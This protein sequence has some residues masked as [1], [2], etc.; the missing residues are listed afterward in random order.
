ML[1]NGLEGYY[2]IINVGGNAARKYTILFQRPL[3]K[4]G[5]TVDNAESE[6]YV[7]F[8]ALYFDIKG[9]IEIPEVITSDSVA[10][11][12]KNYTFDDLSVN[13]YGS[14]YR[15]YKTLDEAKENAY[16]CYYY[17]CY[18]FYRKL[19]MDISFKKYYSY[20]VFLQFKGT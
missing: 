4:D 8:E 15:A 3:N 14:F 13:D 20:V 6:L 18:A 1:Q 10:T 2:C 5:F 19:E 17:I 12:N 9:N 16:N 7:L 11:P